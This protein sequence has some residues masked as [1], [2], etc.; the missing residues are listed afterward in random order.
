MFDLRP[1]LLALGVMLLPL[2]AMMLLPALMGEGWRIFLISSGLTLA[3]GSALILAYWDEM[4]PLTIPQAFLLT[5][6]SWISLASFA[7]LPFAFSSLELSYT[8][9]FFESMSGLTTTG[10]TV[11]TNL[12]SAPKSVL[13]WRALLQWMGG[14]GIIVTA[15]AVLPMLQIGGMQLFR[16]ESSDSSEK[17]LPRAAQIAGQ[18]SLLYAALSLL[19][20]AA[21]FL[22]GMSG[23]D[24][25]AHAM[26][27]IAT[28]GFAAHDSSFAHFDS[29]AIEMVAILFMILGSLPFVLY[30]SALGGQPRRLLTDEQTRGFFGILLTAFFLIFLALLARGLEDPLFAARRALFN[31]VSIMTGTGFTTADYGLWGSF[32]LAIFFLLIFIGGCAGSTSCGVKIFRFLVLW[33]VSLR[34]LKQSIHPQGVFPARYN[35]LP[36]SDS[37]A[38]SVMNFFVLYLAVWALVSCLLILAEMDVVSALS[39][40]ATSLSNVGPGLGS[41]IGPSGSFAPLSAPVKWILAFAMLAGRLEL[42]TV[43]VLFAPSFWRR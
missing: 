4:P 10:S 40:A 9:A 32:A 18:I 14:I 21:Y 24:S 30:L 34:A 28:G 31:T 35:R 13:L 16:T 33:R 1:L 25:A 27:T 8:D 22:A 5:V 23:F 6:L 19:C 26:T 37:V 2:G 15:I 20:M 42:F 7:A 11:I 43:L 12:S 17:I 29:A 36:L 3:C 39:A 38:A 41:L